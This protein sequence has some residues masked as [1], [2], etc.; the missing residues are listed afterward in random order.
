MKSLLAPFRLSENQW[1]VLIDLLRFQT[2]A[3]RFPKLLAG[4]EGGNLYF[5]VGGRGIGSPDSGGLQSLE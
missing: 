4:F 5:P 3:G 1:P 2:G